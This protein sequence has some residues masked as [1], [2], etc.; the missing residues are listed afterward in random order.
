MK[1]TITIET[2][3]SEPTDIKITFNPPIDREQPTTLCE[4]LALTALK[5]MEDEGKALMQ[6]V[7]TA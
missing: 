5:A 3:D 7:F 6:E 2:H 4:H 1:A